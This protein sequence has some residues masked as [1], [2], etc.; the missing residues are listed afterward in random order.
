MRTPSIYSCRRSFLSCSYPFL[1][2]ARPGRPYELLRINTLNVFDRL[3]QVDDNE[4]ASFLVQTEIIPLCLRIME[5]GN[6]VAKTCATYIEVATQS[7]GPEL[8]LS[9][10]REVLC[11][12]Q[13]PC[14]DGGCSSRSPIR[15]RIP[16]S[17]LLLHTPLWPPNC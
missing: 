9:H 15:S 16:S 10:S 7:K 8:C 14:E 4:V 12:C 13:S 6:D 2:A 5:K 1:N 17:D 11:S 3:V